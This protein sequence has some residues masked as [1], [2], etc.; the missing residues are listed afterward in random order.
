MI[1]DFFLQ[2]DI[3]SPLGITILVVA[4]FLVG[5]INTVAGSGT[6]ITYSVFMAFGLPP[7]FA[8]GTIRMGVI[9]QT[10]AS[11]LNF[12]KQKVLDIAKGLLLGLPTVIGSVIGAHIASHINQEIFKYIL[13]GVMFFMLLFLFLNPKRWIEGKLS[14]SR[15][16]PTILHYFVFLLIG[17]YGGFIHIGVGIFLLAA[18]VLVSGY[19]LVKANALKV[20]IVLLYSPFALA[21]YLYNDQVHF[22]MALISSVGNVLGGILASHL[23]V[24][25][26]AHFVRWFLVVIIILFT[27]KILGLF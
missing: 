22:G 10:L 26:G 9:M 13:A 6:I 11:S 27:A 15:K 7:T 19:D 12:N 8:N 23:A 4:G 21:V 1:S 24:S 18:L 25:W 20:F 2:L 17:F 5:F 16:K 14:V 3:Y